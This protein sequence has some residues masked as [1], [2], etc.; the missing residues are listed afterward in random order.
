MQAQELF[1]PYL[2][3]ILDE[4]PYPIYKV[5]RDEYPAYQDERYGFWVLSRF[6][7]IQPALRDW[8]TFSQKPGID[9]DGHGQELIGKGDMLDMD[10]P[11]HDELRKAVQGMKTLTPK[12]VR[13]LEPGIQALVD[14]FVGA[15]EER[16]EADLVKD[17]AH[18]LPLHTGSLTFGFPRE[19]LPML[20][21]LLL[22]SLERTLGEPELPQ[23]AKVAAAKVQNYIEETVA[24]RRKRPREDLA[25]KIAMAEV[26][27]V[28]I[29]EEAVGLLHILFTASTDTVTGL[30]SKSLLHLERH[31]DQRAMLQKDPSLIPS[32]IEEMV[33]YD[34]PVQFNARSATRDVEVHEQ[35]LP[36][37]SR[38]ILLFA[39]A[40]RDERQFDDPD[41]LDV[42][43]KIRRHL[44]F[45]EGIHHCIGAHLGRLQARIVLQTILTRIPEYEIVGPVQW[46]TKSNLRVP[47]SMPAKL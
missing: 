47:T 39:S 4:E 32:A 46:M 11:R 30:V 9:I 2:T 37:G 41:R 14:E 19:D 36:E 25:S 33:R 10:P 26:D 13:A 45:G 43:R 7:D 23:S 1:H 15:F 5:L 20:G 21:E 34:P 17:L 44:G 38:V 18:P 16:G 3:P 8:R 42:T 24:E 31:P 12:G 27:G 6:E 22:A 28:S 29:G 40:N 35:R